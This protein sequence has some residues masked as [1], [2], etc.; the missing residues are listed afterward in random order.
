MGKL[1]NLVCVDSKTIWF[2][3]YNLNVLLNVKKLNYASCST[4]FSQVVDS[5][6]I[7]PR[8][9]NLDIFVIFCSKHSRSSSHRNFISVLSR[10]FLAWWENSC[11]FSIM[12]SSHSVWILSPQHPSHFSI[13]IFSHSLLSWRD[14]IP[15]KI[16]TAAVSF[17]EF[18]MDAI[19]NLVLTFAKKVL[20]SQQF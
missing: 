20:V 12:D 9:F 15:I 16:F 3:G 11:I 14:S 1:Y 5:K 2:E 19:R 4:C 8:M 7:L 17:L 13:A 10:I 18:I 6:W